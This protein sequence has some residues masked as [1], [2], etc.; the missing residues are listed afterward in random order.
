MKIILKFISKKH[1]IFTLI[2]LIIIGLEGFLLPLTIRI[3]V[4]SLTNG[5]FNGLS[6]GVM[7]GITGFIIIGIGSY[8]YQVSMAKLI[9]DFNINVKSLTYKNYIDHYSDSSESK[10]SKVLSF[11]QND[12]KLLEDNYIVA[13]IKMIQT[14]LLA[15]VSTVYVALTNTF[16]AF[17]FVVFAFVPLLLPK[18]T[19]K[20]ISKSADSW[21]GNNEL[22][23]NKLVDTIKG[24]P[25]IK[26]YQR[27]KIFLIG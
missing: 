12:L 2:G 15:L 17:I 19:S 13:Y 23:T 10:S 1:L 22:F 3:V 26:N 27:E 7:M 4:D 24:A 8:I 5:S 6:F 14:I 16:L 9:K 18:F 20:R 21:T 11:I 25:T